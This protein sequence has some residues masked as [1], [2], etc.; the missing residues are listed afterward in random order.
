MRWNKMDFKKR[1]MLLALFI[2]L[3]IVLGFML[4]PEHYLVLLWLWPLLGLVFSL[5]L[6]RMTKKEKAR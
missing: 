3:G 6:N 4:Y 2:F 5:I 1:M